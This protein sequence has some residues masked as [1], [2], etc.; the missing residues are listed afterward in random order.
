MSAGT[1]AGVRGEA[2]GR[3]RPG[4]RE[5][6]LW[7]CLQGARPALTRRGG[8]REVRAPGRAGQA[9]G[10][11]ARGA[12]RRMAGLWSRP[13]A[14]LPSAVRSGAAAPRRG[15]AEEL[16]PRPEFRGVE[17]AEVASAHRPA[18]AAHGAVPVL[19]VERREAH[20]RAAAESA[21][22][23]GAENGWRW[24]V[25]LAGR[26]SFRLANLLDG[27]LRITCDGPAR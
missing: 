3:A 14:R 6:G 12:L 25:L 4:A 20:P 19:E 21:A 22:G 8:R 7:T 15:S 26:G 17:S 10:S 13:G 23:A 16:A 1:R 5:R 2:T 27:A 18:S 24:N 11:A 9:M